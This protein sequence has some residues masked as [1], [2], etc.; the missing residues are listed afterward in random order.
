[1][2][3]PR[4]AGRL[5]CLLL[6]AGLAASCNRSIEPYDPNEKVEQPDLS[7]IFPEGAGRP[8]PAA[9]PIMPEPASPRGAAAGMRGASAE[10][11]TDGEPLRGTIR[12][13]PE[14]EGRVPPGAILF[15]IARTGAGG[16][17]TAVQR[18]ADPRFPLPFEIGPGDRMIRSLP[19][20]GPFRL[21]ARIDADHNAMTRN[22]GDLAG[23]AEGTHSPGDRDI[24]L[25]I[26][27]V[28]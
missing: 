4:L 10:A 6:L 22:P 21:T 26:D 16:P 18:I 5:A 9:A 11:E 1:M 12:L 13:A 20:T 19:F 14:L 25:V 27:Q 15:L 17:P 24:D 7:R 23:E 8:D 3:G 2:P 28:L